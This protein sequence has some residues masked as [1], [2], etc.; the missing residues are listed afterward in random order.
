MNVRRAGKRKRERERE[1]EER[2]EEEMEER[3]CLRGGKVEIRAV[4]VVTVVSSS[5]SSSGRGVTG[6]GY[7]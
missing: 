7:A 5:G 6:T 4:T 2:E 1:E 3:R